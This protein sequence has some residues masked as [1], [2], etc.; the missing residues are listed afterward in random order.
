MHPGGPLCGA[1]VHLLLCALTQAAVVCVP[2]RRGER[3]YRQRSGDRPRTSVA[4]RDRPRPPPSKPNEATEAAFALASSAAFALA[5][6]F[7]ASFAFRSRSRSKLFHFEPQDGGAWSHTSFNIYTRVMHGDSVAN[8]KIKLYAGPG[9]PIL[10]LSRKKFNV[11]LYFI[12]TIQNTLDR[13]DRASRRGGVRV[14]GGRC[15]RG[16]A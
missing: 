1:A 13:E 4:R 5:F 15:A 9:R 6:R 12:H 16:A 2:G 10:P 3:D 8:I 7:L 11:R 14:R